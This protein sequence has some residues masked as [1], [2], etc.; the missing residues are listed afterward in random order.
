LIIRRYY[1]GR[2]CFN[3]WRLLFK[4]YQLKQLTKAGL[5]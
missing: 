5:F 2:F 3:S 1:S 4:I